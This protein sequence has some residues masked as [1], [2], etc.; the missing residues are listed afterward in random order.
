MPCRTSPE[1]S[2]KSRDVSYKQNYRSAHVLSGFC[3]YLMLK[4]ESCNALNFYWEMLYLNLCL[5]SS[6]NSLNFSWFS[7]VHLG[8][9]HDSTPITPQLLHSQ[10]FFNFSCHPTVYMVWILT[11]SRLCGLVLQIQRSRVRLPALSDFLRSSGS[12]KGSTQPSEDN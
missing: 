3:P 9:C 11:A 1:T 6:Y 8:Y 12:G 2:L 4:I 5:V 10:T 7:S